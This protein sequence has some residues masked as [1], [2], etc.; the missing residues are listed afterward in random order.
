MSSWAVRQAGQADLALLADL[1]R[2]GDQAFLNSDLP[3][4]AA[5]EPTP[6]DLLAPHIDAGGGW[7]AEDTQG[8]AGG[9]LVAGV[10]EDQ[11]VIFQISVALT[12]QGTGAGGL[13]MRTA[14]NRGRQLGCRQAVLTTFRD[15]AWNAPW[16]GRFGF[17]I[18]AEADL[19]PALRAMR[20][21]EALAGFDM[22][23]RCAMALDLQTP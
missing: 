11:F 9:F 10:R 16:Y 17:R 4:L 7:I 20:Q 18:L 22:D 3:G 5:A 14:L 6:T 8:R 19:T 15:I 12:D 13:L 21:K 2:S 1:E 23:R